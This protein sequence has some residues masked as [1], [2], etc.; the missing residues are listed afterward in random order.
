MHGAARE[1]ETDV[2]GESYPLIRL[3]I[4]LLGAL[5]GY[6]LAATMGARELLAGPNTTGYVAVL[7][8]LL[9]FVLGG[10]VSIVAGRWWRRTM[11]RLNAVP[12][13]A[14]LAVVV[15]TIV[16]LLLTVLLNNVLYD[17][18]GFTW[19]WSLLIALI[20]V[21]GVSA[22][23]VGNRRAFLPVRLPPQDQEIPAAVK[24]QRPKLIDTSAI[25]DGRVVDVYSA[26]FLEG[27]VLIPRFILRELQLIADDADEERRKRGRRG[28]EVL[29]RL[30]AVPGVVT[31]VIDDNP[32]EVKEVD[33][34]LLQ[35]AVTLEADLITT[36]YN[37]EQ[38]A[39][40]QGIRVLNPNQLAAAVRVLYLPGDQ[41]T[42][43]VSKQGR[44]A[45]Q[46][47]AYLSD[48]TMVVID[49][50]AGL[51]GN[52]IQAV[53]TSSLQTNVGRMIFAKPVSGPVDMPEAPQVT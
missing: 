24:I 13:D 49:G 22:L 52:T 1:R 5:A 38:V 31:E 26:N 11:A 19:Y 43:T 53:V 21:L 30:S 47:V 25:I 50:A 8:F 2:K 6:L 36:D 23:L 34:K 39:G 46:G 14:W 17:I 3:A 12:P 42:L 40:V 4:S 16:G 29:S 10:P 44:E 27:T 45:G 9:F 37:L 7:G 15:G 20:L 18:P 28:L 41:I 35:L 51:M 33:G 32:A 48:G